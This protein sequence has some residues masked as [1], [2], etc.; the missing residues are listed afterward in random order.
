MKVWLRSK[1]ISNCQYLYDAWSSLQSVSR[2]YPTPPLPVLPCEPSPCWASIIFQRRHQPTPVEPSHSS[3]SSECLFYI[4]TFIAITLVIFITIITIIIITNTAIITII[5]TNQQSNGH[6]LHQNACL[7]LHP[8]WLSST[9]N[10]TFITVHSCQTKNTH[11]DRQTGKY[12]YRKENIN[13]NGQAHRLT[14]LIRYEFSSQT[15]SSAG[16]FGE[17]W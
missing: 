16:W 2:L 7:V 11:I 6:L 10:N 1:M 17:I 8:S 4:I 3:P 14:K 13:R 9:M 5:I 15:I 12:I